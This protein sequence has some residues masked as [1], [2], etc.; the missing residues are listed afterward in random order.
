MTPAQHLG[1]AQR[2]TRQRP[3]STGHDDL[4]RGSPRRRP[5]VRHANQA[6]DGNGQICGATRRPQI[7]T[8]AAAPLLLLLGGSPRTAPHLPSPRPVPATAPQR[9]PDGL[10]SKNV[11]HPSTG[12][13][14]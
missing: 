2:R 8:V 14:A 13:S 11:P 1:R 4:L 10:T 3:A 7:T 9:T 12:P 5:L 6:G